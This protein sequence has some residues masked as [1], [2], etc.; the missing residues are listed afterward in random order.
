M[1]VRD[2]FLLIVGVVDEKLLPFSTEGQDDIFPSVTVLDMFLCMVGIVDEKL[3]PFS[4]EG[5]SS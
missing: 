3:L 1:T 4:T 5:K 2:V